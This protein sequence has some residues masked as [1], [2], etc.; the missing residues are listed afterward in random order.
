[1]QLVHMGGRVY[2]YNVGRFLS[3]DPF[4]QGAGSQGINPYSYIM[5]NPLS[6]TDPSG[7]LKVCDTFIVCGHDDFVDPKINK[8]VLLLDEIAINHNGASSKQSTSAPTPES[9]EEIGSKDN[10]VDSDLEKLPGF[11]NNTEMIEYFEKKFGAIYKGT[12][13]KGKT[14]NFEVDLTSTE[15]EFTPINI[16]EETLYH[17]SLDGSGL[18]VSP[19]RV[20]GNTNLK[21]K[22]DESI[23]KTL[24]NEAFVTI[25]TLTSEV[26]RVTSIRKGTIS[27]FKVNFESGLVREGSQR[28]RLISE[29]KNHGALSFGK[30]LK[31]ER[32]AL[33]SRLPKNAKRV[34]PGTIMFIKEA[35]K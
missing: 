1:M 24:V 19:G 12:D 30:S 31:T 20:D 21:K 18:E 10:S 8:D 33:R 17:G 9:A 29:T 23:F 11:S 2:D 4:I 32:F 13:D 34:H 35:L 14:G 28:V 15:Y 16:V 27:R 5:N 22:I 6:G 26:N 3:V 25:H 7:Y